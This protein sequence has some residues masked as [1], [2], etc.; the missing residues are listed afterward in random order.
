MGVSIMPTDL[1]ISADWQTLLQHCL[2]GLTTGS[3]IA[4]IALGYTIVYGII[5]L[6]NFAHGDL[7]MLGSFL[8]LTLLGALGLTGADPLLLVLGIALIL[9]TVACFG[10]VVNVA[11]DRL[12]YRP[13]RGQPKL[14]PLVSA[15]GVSFVFMNIGLF[16]GG[17]ADRNFPDL[18]PATNL[19]GDGAVQFTLKDLLVIAV[20]LPLMVGLTLFVQYSRLGK[21]M[22][23][24]AQDPVAAQLMGIPVDRVVTAAFA[25]GGALAG[26]ASVAYALYINTVSFQMGYQIGLFAFTAAVLGGIG[27]IPGAVLGGLVMG[28]VRALGS[29]YFGER[30]TA[31]LVFV[32]LIAIL[33]FRPAGLLGTRAKE[34]V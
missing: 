10:A 30:W 1:L 34:K 32:I 11:V 23:A 27:R 21:A 2:I 5:E 6:V 15:I 26:A 3:L 9:V 8:A 19:L 12:V 4:L 24:T 20:T 25:L 31:A 17:A 16:W 13:L 14:A 33:V 29:A 28:L 22:R 18:V 7:V